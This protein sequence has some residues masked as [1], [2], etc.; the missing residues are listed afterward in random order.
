MTDFEKPDLARD[1]LADGESQ[2]QKSPAQGI[3]TLFNTSS[4][5]TYDSQG[6]ITID[7]QEKSRLLRKID[8]Q[9]LPI[10]T[11]LYLMS[12]LDRASIGNANIAGMAKDLHLT[13]KQYNIALSI[14]FVSYASFEVCGSA[15]VSI[16][17]VVSLNTEVG[18]VAWCVCG[19]DGWDI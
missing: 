3:E 4:L 1:T 17:A 14:M 13:P 6:G 19:N 9:L 10:I 11:L 2:C 15:F 12:F 5:T 7:A 16:S 8:W 18:K